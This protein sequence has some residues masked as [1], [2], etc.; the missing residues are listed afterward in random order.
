[1]RREVREEVKQGHMV[2]AEVDVR[3]GDV[4]RPRV[5]VGFV[6]AAPVDERHCV[7]LLRERREVRVEVL[8]QR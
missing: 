6:D 5:E 4:V 3:D 1:M 2:R 8:L 7:V